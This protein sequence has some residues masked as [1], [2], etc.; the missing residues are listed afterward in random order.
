MFLILI[1]LYLFIVHVYNM[2]YIQK[3][4]KTD[5]VFTKKGMNNK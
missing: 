3:N 1:L 5:A 2:K 4:V